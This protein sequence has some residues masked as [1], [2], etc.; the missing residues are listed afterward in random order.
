M[1]DNT[2]NC[3]NSKKPFTRE[4]LHEVVKDNVNLQFSA[5]MKVINAE[6]AHFIAKS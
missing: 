6:K 2:L 1:V 4:N 3:W 5:G